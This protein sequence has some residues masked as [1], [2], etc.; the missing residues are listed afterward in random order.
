M[1]SF[2]DIGADK[3]RATNIKII[4]ALCARSYFLG[5]CGY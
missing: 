1:F 5:I 4:F 3:R 2:I